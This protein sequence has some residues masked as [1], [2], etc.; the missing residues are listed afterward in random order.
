MPIPPAA[1]VAHPRPVDELPP[2]EEFP[3]LY[4]AILD[5]IDRLERSG[6]RREAA[7]IRQ[8]AIRA[9]STAW[10]AAHRRRLEMVHRRVERAL[11]ARGRSTLTTNLRSTGPA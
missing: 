1:A 9:Y 3:Q 2:A 7:R 4:R 10:D 8:E 11:E 6:E 5:G